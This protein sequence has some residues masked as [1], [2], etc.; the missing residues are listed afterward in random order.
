MQRSNHVTHV[1]NECI[2]HVLAPKQTCRTRG[3]S[4]STEHFPR[5]VV[6]CLAYSRRRS[7]LQYAGG[8]DFRSLT[9]EK[10][11]RVRYTSIRVATF[12]AVAGLPLMRRQARRFA[13]STT[14]DIEARLVTA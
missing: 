2:V 14:G 13:L 4:V 10:N 1:I 7:T 9:H 5:A 11:M 8:R 6:Q 12:R 3:A